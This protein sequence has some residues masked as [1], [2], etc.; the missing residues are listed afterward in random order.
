MG[1]V[2]I[3]P[4]IKKTADRLDKDGN[5]I[6]PKTKQIIEAVEKPYVPT[7]EELAGVA[8]KPAEATNKP[9]EA[10]SSPIGD[11]IKKK[12]QEAV[13]TELSKID[14]GAMVAKA[15]GEALK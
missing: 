5:V 8:K 13:Q 3:S 1:D 14:I 10:Q 15:I 6:N 7:L 12:V 2:Q 11:I 9:I 4:N